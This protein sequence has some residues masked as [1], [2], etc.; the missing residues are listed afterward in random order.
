MTQE[1]VDDYPPMYDEISQAFNLYPNDGVIFSWGERIYNP[2][3]SVIPAQLIPHEAIHGERQ[4]KGASNVTLLNICDWWRQ[5][6]D[7][8]E[9]RLSEEIHAHRA[10]YQWFMDNGN[11]SQRRS[12][13][14]RTAARLGSPLYGGIITQAQAMNILRTH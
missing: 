10:E 6:M 11:R 1:I 13:L 14:K 3:G 2:G 9:F 4:V 7:S 8:W 12:A 5:Y